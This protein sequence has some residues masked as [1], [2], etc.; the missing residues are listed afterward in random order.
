[1][2]QPINPSNLSSEKKDALI[3]HLFDQIGKLSAEIQ[4]LRSQQKKGK[5]GILNASRRERL[6]SI[7]F[8]PFRLFPDQ[9]GIVPDNLTISGDELY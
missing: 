1:M 9:V 3:L 7:A 8:T 2:Q 6:A 4:D 5:Y